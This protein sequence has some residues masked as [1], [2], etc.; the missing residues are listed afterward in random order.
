MIENWETRNRERKADLETKQKRVGAETKS[1]RPISSDCFPDTTK[2]MH[3]WTHRDCNSVYEQALA[4]QNLGKVGE[5]VDKELL[6]F[7]SYW[8]GKNQN[9]LLM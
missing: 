1:Q 7:D 8:L 2:Q 5:W 3:K 9:S 6:A 4:R